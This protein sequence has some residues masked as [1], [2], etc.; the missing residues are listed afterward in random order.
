MNNAQQRPPARLIAALSLVAISMAA[1]VHAARQDTQPVE[2]ADTWEPLRYFVGSWEGTGQSFGKAAKTTR[3][4]EFVLADQFLFSKNKSVFEAAESQDQGEVHEDI[5]IFSYDTGRK[6]F[7]LRSFHVEGFVNRYVAEKIAPDGRTMV[8]TTEH[9]ENIAP[10]WRARE[11][12]RIINENEFE[13]TFELA[14][15]DGEFKL[16]VSNR[17]KRKL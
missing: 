5:A 3:T 11:T 6:K 1:I 12:Y 4:Y 17:L 9:I 13:E 8:F 7:V 2:T 16:C 15:P 14:Q 10:G